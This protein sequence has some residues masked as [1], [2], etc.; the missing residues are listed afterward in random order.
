MRR[1]LAYVAAFTGMGTLFAGTLLLAA[2]VL[3]VPQAGGT[4]S[5]TPQ[6]SAPS[7]EAGM[8]EI[9][10]FDLGFNPTSPVVPQAGTYM[11][12]LINDGA[13]THNLTFDDGTVISADA[14]QTSIGRVTIPAAGM[15]FHCSVP[16]H[17]DAGMV[18][19]VS[20]G[21]PGSAQP[22]QTMT[23]GQMRDVD[24]A[25]TAQFPA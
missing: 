20:V 19:S 10:A 16:G 14:G 21:A 11:V 23:P 2:V 12:H 8:L 9:H 22:S 7:G 13:I 4:Q 24:A 6:P 18:G 1:A 17:A 5:P 25:V 15:A 3:G